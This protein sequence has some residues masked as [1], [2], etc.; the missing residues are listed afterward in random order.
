[1]SLCSSVSIPFRGS[2]FVKPYSA[3]AERWGR[4]LWFKGFHPLSGKWVCQGVARS[5]IPLVGS[6]FHPLSGK[7]VCQVKT[8]ASTTENKCFHPLSGK[9][10]CQDKGT[11][12]YRKQIVRVSI[13]FR[14]SEFVKREK[15]SDLDYGLGVSIP[16]RGSEFVKQQ[17][18]KESASP[19]LR[20]PS[21]FGEVSLSRVRSGNLTESGFQTPNLHT[22]FPCQLL[23]A[24][25]QKS[26]VFIVQN[27]YLD[28]HR[29]TSTEKWGFQR[30]RDLCRWANLLYFAMQFSR[31]WR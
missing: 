17:K 13:P 8:L 25:W 3:I 1:M 7:W 19:S 6:S 20:F 21:P 2:E 29:H 15:L 28:C 22:F 10:V 9:W 23:S 16:F 14:G 27:P 5:K 30:S 18:V 31:F 11:T 12:L 24:Y 4:S 26:P